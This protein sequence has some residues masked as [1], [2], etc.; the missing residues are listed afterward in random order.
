MVFQQNPLE[1][2]HFV[3]QLTGPTGQFWQM[4]SAFK[5]QKPRIHFLGGDIFRCRRGCLVR[6]MPMNFS[7]DK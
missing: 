3:C 7:R 4:E 5:F 1:K 6:S 2:A